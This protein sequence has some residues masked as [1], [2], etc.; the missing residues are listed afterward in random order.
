MKPWETKVENKP[1]EFWIYTNVAGGM[2][3]HE[4]RLQSDTFGMYGL[5]YKVPRSNIWEQLSENHVIE[6][7]AYE[8]LEKQNKAMREALEK[9]ADYYCVCSI[10][11]EI[12]PQV[13]AQ[14]ALVANPGKVAE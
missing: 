14:R 3:A 10:D 4:D 5:R 13:E 11:D 9:I 12:I 1:K 8:A 6:Y 2:I 7:S